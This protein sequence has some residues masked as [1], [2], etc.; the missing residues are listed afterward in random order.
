MYYGKCG[1]KC[2]RGLSGLAWRALR[3]AVGK[4]LFFALRTGMKE[5][6]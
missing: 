3:L 6:H 5:K 2:E 4:K 1:S